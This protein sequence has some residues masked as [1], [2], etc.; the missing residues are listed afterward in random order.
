MTTQTQP[1]ATSP[2]RRWSA[3]QMGWPRPQRVALAVALLVAVALPFV[4]PDRSWLSVAT[5]GAVWLT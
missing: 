3:V 2:T 5:L 1:V 4:V